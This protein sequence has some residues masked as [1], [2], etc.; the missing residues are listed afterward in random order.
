[1]VGQHGERFGPHAGEILDDWAKDARHRSSQLRDIAARLRHLTKN[2]VSI[3]EPVVFSPND[4][5]EII[6]QIE[7]LEELAR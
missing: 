4:F 6:R 1:M 7:R 3:L 5:H 2:R